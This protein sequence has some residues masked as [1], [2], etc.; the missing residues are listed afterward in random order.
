M[1]NSVGE[2]GISGWTHRLYNHHYD[3]NKTCWNSKGHGV[4][5]KSWNVTADRIHKLGIL[6]DLF[7]FLLQQLHKL[8]TTTEQL[9]QFISRNTSTEK[10]KY[11]QNIIK[12]NRMVS[13]KS[14]QNIHY[15]WL[16]I[17]FE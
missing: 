7:N 12:Y 17:N 9:V 6:Q 5:K 16:E 4:A 11:T 15:L 14:V 1:R 3:S 8:Q 2:G 10:K 13:S